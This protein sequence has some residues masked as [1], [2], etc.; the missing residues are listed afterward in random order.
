V[1]ALLDAA[2]GET[3]DRDADSSSIDFDAAADAASI[4][5]SNPNAQASPDCQTPMADRIYTVTLQ[6]TLWTFYPPSAEFVRIGTLSCRPRYTDT[7]FSMAV[8]RTGTAYVVY[9]DGELFRVSTTTAQCAATSF[10]PPSSNYTT[11]G[12]GFVGE[13]NA[14]GTLYIA[15]QSAGVLATLNLQTFQVSNIGPLSVQAELTGT[16]D[17]RLFAFYQQL[18]STAIAQL[19]PST[20]AFV[21]ITNLV[22]LPAGNGWAIAFWGGDLYLFTAPGS[23]FGSSRVTRFRPSDGSQVTMAMLDETIVG[24]GVST[25]APNM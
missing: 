12:M 16:G 6:G 17:G 20:A 14:A 10:A 8:D 7:P 23:L 18:Q 1:A 9:T 21:S 3:L 2:Q 11:F 24:A 19:D 22:N 15:P 13:S 4:D 5:Q 25:C